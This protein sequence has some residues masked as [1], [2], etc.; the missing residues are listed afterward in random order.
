MVESYYL[1]VYWGARKETAG[2]CAQR[3]AGLIAC[4]SR[5]DPALEKWYEKGQSLEDALRFRLN[6][7]AESLESLLV[8][9]SNRSDVTGE[10][11]EN[12]GFRL[13]AW[14]GKNDGEAATLTVRCGCYA[15]APILNS[16]IV[17]LP[18]SGPAAARLLQTKTL[19]AAMRCMVSS[20]DPDWGVVMSRAFQTRAFRVSPMGPPVGWMLYLPRRRGTVPEFKPPVRRVYLD[21]LGVLLI[22]TDDVFTASNQ[23]H[24]EVADR[25]GSELKREGLLESAQ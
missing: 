21:D 1:G 6:L 15:D 11:I 22:T 23:T 4:L 16:C 19:I 5:C 17:G 13:S 24:V 10:R 18:F 3:A 2:G 9:E 8:R 20:W 7:T 25:V 14:T 12:L